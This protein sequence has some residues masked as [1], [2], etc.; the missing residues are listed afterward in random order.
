VT[1]H[2]DMYAVEGL[3]NAINEFEG[4]VVLI[5]H[6]RHFVR[7]TADDVYSLVDGNLTLLENGVDEYIQSIEGV[8]FN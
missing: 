6:D 8:D 4:A 1:N 3:I 7:E 5:S 2:L